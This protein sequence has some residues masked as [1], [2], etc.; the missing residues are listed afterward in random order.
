MNPLTYTELEEA[1][2]N[3]KLVIFHPDFGYEAWKDGIKGPIVLTTV[4]RMDTINFV[5]YRCYNNKCVPCTS[6]DISYE[7]CGHHQMIDT[8]GFHIYKKIEFIETKKSTV[9][10]V[11]LN[12]VFVLY[13]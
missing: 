11:L 12:P 1:F 13:E 9:I 5:G 3:N 8:K 6:K 10:K 2:K 7:I 4:S